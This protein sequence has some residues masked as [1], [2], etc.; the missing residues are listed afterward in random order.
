VSV[1]QTHFAIFIPKECLPLGPDSGL[2]FE[3]LLSIKTKNRTEK[4]ENILSWNGS[5][6]PVKYHTRTLVSGLH[7]FISF[8]QLKS[9]GFSAFSHVFFQERR[10]ILYTGEYWNKCRIRCFRSQYGVV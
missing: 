8:S 6:P 2:Q 9:A 7:G 4:T 5:V 1:V 10:R 3:S